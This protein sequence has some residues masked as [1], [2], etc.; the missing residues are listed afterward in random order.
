MKNIE[1]KYNKK[2]ENK[3]KKTNFIGIKRP[4]KEFEKTHHIFEYLN[5]NNKLAKEFNQYNY[6]K[7]KTDLKLNQIEN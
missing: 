4:D 6:E 5:I 2:W 3:I 1:E 7:I